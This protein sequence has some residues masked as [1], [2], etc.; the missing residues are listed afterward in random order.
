MCSVTAGWLVL[1]FLPD[2]TAALKEISRVLRPGGVLSF[3]VWDYPG[4][5]I[6]FIDA[7]WNAAAEVDPKAVELNEGA[8]FPFCTEAGLREIKDG[9][10]LR[11]HAEHD[12]NWS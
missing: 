9:A 2:K 5:G 1:N 3:Y 4:G 12:S 10:Y 8:R 6:G 7:F 11:T